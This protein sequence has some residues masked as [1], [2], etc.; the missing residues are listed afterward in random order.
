M[1]KPIIDDRTLEACRRGDPEAFRLL[2]PPKKIGPNLGKPPPERS[3][4]LHNAPTVT[5]PACYFASTA[6][7]Y[8]PSSAYFAYALDAQLLADSTRQCQHRLP[9]DECSWPLDCGPGAVQQMPGQDRA[10]WVRLD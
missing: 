7:R 4:G 6:R 9:I 1:T 5:L 10:E 2:F 3:G 8:L